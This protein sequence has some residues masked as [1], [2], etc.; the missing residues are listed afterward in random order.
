MSGPNIRS[1]W[2]K[3]SVSNALELD[4]SLPLANCSPHAMALLY[5][6]DYCDKF[7]IDVFLKDFWGSANDLNVFLISTTYSFL[8]DGKYSG[9]EQNRTF[10]TFRPFC[11]GVKGIYGHRLE[12]PFHL[13]EQNREVFKGK[14]VL[15]LYFVWLVIF[16]ALCVV[17][18]LLIGKWM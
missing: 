7:S 17:G 2:T 1:W 11:N 12:L 9:T 3:C 13:V 15:L 8:N 10:F 6:A 16:F 14:V 18:V 5:G 4:P